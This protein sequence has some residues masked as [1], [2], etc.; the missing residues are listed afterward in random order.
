M[1]YR[2]RQIS[3]WEFPPKGAY[4]VYR[5]VDSGLS[6]ATC[7]FVFYDEGKLVTDDCAP[8][9]KTFLKEV[10]PRL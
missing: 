2:K 7:T 10:E 5:H 3:Q 4:V 6:N 1:A 9:V 8:D